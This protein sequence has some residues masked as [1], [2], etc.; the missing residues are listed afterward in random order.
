MTLKHK[1]TDTL[2]P[3][4][5]K[6]GAQYS[7]VVSSKY[8][9]QIWFQNM[10]LEQNQRVFIYE[11]N[12]WAVKAHFEAAYCKWL[13][14]NVI[15]FAQY[16]FENDEPA[17]STILVMTVESSAAAYASALDSFKS[18]IVRLLNIPVH[19]VGSG[20]VSLP[21][22]CNTLDVMVANG[23]WTIRCPT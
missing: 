22:A 11:G 18:Q 9:P 15:C 8:E 23:L 5:K 17:P 2:R 10:F 7:P 16:R 13:K 19:L 14:V 6:L 20:D 3:V 12:L 21:V 1:V 4:L